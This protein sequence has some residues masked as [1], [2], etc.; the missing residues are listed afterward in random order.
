MNSLLR[1]PVLYC[2]AGT[3]LALGFEEIRTGWWGLL[4]LGFLISLYG[5][6]AAGPKDEGRFQVGDNCYFI[7]FVYTLSIIT[8]T[9]GLDAERLL[10]GAQDSLPP[11]L[12]TVGI[13]LGTSVV[14]MVWRF[15]LTHGVRVGE[16]AF[17]DAVRE[18]AVAATGLKGVL[19][20]LHSTADGTKSAV[21]GIVRT[22][23]TELEQL[24]AETRSHMH[25]TVADATG[26]LT[27]LG[28]NATAASRQQA[29]AI[30]K[31]AADT[32]ET[33]ATL[34]RTTQ[35]ATDALAEPLAAIGGRLEQ[36]VAETRSRMERDAAKAAA[37]LATLGEN[38][39]AS[40]Q[41]QATAFTTFADN[42]AEAMRSLQETT[43][44]ATD[45]VARSLNAALPSLQD[46]ARNVETTMQ[47][48]GGALEAGARQ[49]LER[50][51]NGV[52]DALQANT[53]ADARQAMESA[54]GA[55]AQTV[56]EVQRTLAQSVTSL[57]E[58]TN[59]A[60]ARAEE[61]R[62]TLAALHGGPDQSGL[63]A[64]STAVARLQSA[65]VELNEQL[66]LLAERQ[67]VATAAA[68]S[69]GEELKGL[70]NTLAAMPQ[71]APAPDTG[72]AS[73][74]SRLFRR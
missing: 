46:H 74:W 6:L 33:L 67:A 62:A 34:Q 40:S 25:G 50:L 63:D 12:T 27:T 70:S 37:T 56:A 11:L 38:S 2:V 14:G 73:W 13:A 24:V 23:G 58:A 1:Y 26:A 22:A 17:Q 71:S 29:E 30:A 44:A 49:A 15:G 36:V 18:A 31:F 51:S 8:A 9:L 57:T 35:A 3:L 10:A 5:F 64:T 42:T 54:V 21:S 28:K 32:T 16:D 59:L 4:V 41:Q 39:V 53:F 60:T 66:P 72:Q 65:V 68:N 47:R 7:G 61:A 19:E 52:A 69:Y 45:A 48:V 20:E 43:Q 55:H